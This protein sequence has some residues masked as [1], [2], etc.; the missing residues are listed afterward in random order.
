MLSSLGGGQIGLGDI[1]P[2]NE[3]FCLLHNITFLCSLLSR[4]AS[5]VGG[6]GHYS[7]EPV[8]Y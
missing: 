1:N 3:L 6:D 2:M 5:R 7:W 4:S 8:P